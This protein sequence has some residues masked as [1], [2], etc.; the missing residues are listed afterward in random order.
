MSLDVLNTQQESPYIDYASKSQA[1][2][3]PYVRR[4]PE[5][6]NYKTLDLNEA[7][8]IGIGH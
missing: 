7:K 4:D 8:L 3:N 6:Y 1:V 2:S 5:S